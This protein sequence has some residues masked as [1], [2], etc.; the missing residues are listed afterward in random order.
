MGSGG[1]AAH[2]GPGLE[3]VQLWIWQPRPGP[4]PRKTLGRE[5]SEAQP[6]SSCGTQEHQQNSFNGFIFY[7]LSEQEAYIFSFLSLFFSSFSFPKRDNKTRRYERSK[8]WSKG[9]G[10][11][12]P[13]NWETETN[14]PL[15]S[16][17]TSI[18]LFTWIIIFS[19]FLLLLLVFFISLL[20]V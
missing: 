18:L 7:I 11:V 15:L 5:K 4:H 13:K 3:T 14:V 2:R 8:N 17:R 1:P 6:C 12:N 9:G 20:S 16:H 19:L 10:K